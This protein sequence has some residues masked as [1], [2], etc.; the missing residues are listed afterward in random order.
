MLGSL[1][2]DNKNAY[3][4][5][6][7][8]TN[9]STNKK[10]LNPQVQT[11]IGTHTRYIVVAGQTQQGSDRPSYRLPYFPKPGVG[12]CLQVLWSTNGA[13]GTDAYPLV[14]LCNRTKVNMF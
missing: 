3:I 11:G 1:V 14:R 8:H 10:H 13:L 5:I 6:H 7:T 2:L 12:M 9:K 4:Y